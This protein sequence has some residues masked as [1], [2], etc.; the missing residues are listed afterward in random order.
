MV[1]TLLVYWYALLNCQTFNSTHVDFCLFVSQVWHPWSTSNENNHSNNNNNKN[2][3][4]SGLDEACCISDRL[5]FSCG[6]KMERK[7]YLH[8]K[9]CYKSSINIS[10]KRRIE[11]GKCTRFR[12]RLNRE[13]PTRAFTT[14]SPDWKHTKLIRLTRTVA[15]LALCPGQG[16]SINYRQQLAT[17][18]FAHAS[19]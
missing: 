16:S 13:N 7:E 8:A 15:V 10:T 5:A 2:S 4:L 14:N 12:L 6:K 18:N 1:L 17:S 11:S 19:N 3:D 9:D